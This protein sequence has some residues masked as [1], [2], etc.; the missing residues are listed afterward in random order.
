MFT[1][2]TTDQP[3]D[4][5]LPGELACDNEGA[6]AVVSSDENVIEQMT[7]YFSFLAVGSGQRQALWT[8]PYVDGAGTG[9]LVTVAVPVYSN[10]TDRYYNKVH[11]LNK[12][13]LF[14]LNIPMVCS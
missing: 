12:Y 9:L 3:S 8:S 10:V 4:Q 5:V 11:I 2:L 13:I 7:P 6:M 14:L 1:F